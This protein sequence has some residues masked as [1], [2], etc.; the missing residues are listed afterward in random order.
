ML[1]SRIHS[2]VERAKLEIVNAVIS[3]IEPLVLRMLQEQVKMSNQVSTDLQSLNTS[4]TDISS[5]I[6]TLSSQMQQLKSGTTVGQPQTEENAAL[7]HDLATRAEAADNALKAIT[8]P[9][10]TTGS[11]TVTG[12]TGG[13]TV[14]GS[15]GSDTVSGATS[16][17]DQQPS[18]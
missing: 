14:S 8:Q 16:D 10:D 11:D 5:Q 7:I 13:D 9:S 1:K 2:L 17:T 6:S 15:T 18:S 3:G 12:S 4:L